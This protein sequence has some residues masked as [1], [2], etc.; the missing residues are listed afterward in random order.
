MFGHSDDFLH[1]VNTGRRSFQV[2]MNNSVRWNIR[3]FGWSIGVGILVGR[4]FVAVVLIDKDG[5][6]VVLRPELYIV[7]ILNLQD[8]LIRYSHLVQVL[9]VI[10]LL[11]SGLEVG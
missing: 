6:I 7:V 10:T 8:C 4:H 3:S 11:T 1:V 2:E 5:H 9:S